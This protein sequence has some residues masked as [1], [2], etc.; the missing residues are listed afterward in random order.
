MLTIP[1]QIIALCKADSIRKNFRVHFPNGENADLTNS[2]IIS[3]SVRF[4][5]SVCSKDVL[6]FGLAEASRIEFECVNVQNVYGMTIECGIEVDTSSL[7]AAQITAIQGNPGDGTLVLV[8]DSDIG[9]GFYRVPYGVFTVTSC[10]RSAGAMW[11]RR[12]EAYSADNVSEL[13]SILKKK[14]SVPYSQQE[15][16]QNIP[17]LLAGETQDI[18]N[19]TLTE[20]AVSFTNPNLSWN[21]NVSWEYGGDT[22]TFYGWGNQNPKGYLINTQATSLFRFQCEADM[23]VH[24][25]I[26]EDV[27]ALEIPGALFEKLRNAL[28]P[29]I[30]FGNVAVYAVAFDNPEDSGYVYPYSPKGTYIWYPDFGHTETMYLEK[31]SSPY[32]TYNFSPFVTNVTLKQYALNDNILQLLNLKTKYTS[33]NQ[34]SQYTFADTI[35]IRSL[36]EGNLELSGSF[37]STSRTTGKLK[38]VTLSK[39][40]PISMNTDEYAE[41]WWDEYDIAPIGS[42]TLAYKDIDLGEEQTILYEFGGGLST[43]D[44]TNNYLLKN[45][46]VSVNDLSGQTVEEYVIDLLD[47]YF[48]P[49]ITDIAFTPVQL[50]ALGLPYIEAGD[51]L[52]ID[53]GNSGTVGTYV[54]NRTI[55]GEQFLQD[56]IEAQGGEIIGNA[57]SA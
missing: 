45:L 57:R 39:S 53:D 25:Q 33:Q 41:L 17:L 43:Y 42:I 40:S 34:Y 13:S 21:G 51:Y 26:Y 8:G 7:S 55:S 16:V 15:M 4:T 18:S 48:I 11:K 37:G 6:Q 54:L 2:D 46:A 14:L 24:E 3:G 10:P 56:E 19:L 1:S 30:M 49:N 38:R 50:D 47:N 20:T 23:T 27:Q 36:Q 29:G 22:Y 9:Y 31:N 28:Q 12:V 35:D 52:E 44:M 5:E 32:K